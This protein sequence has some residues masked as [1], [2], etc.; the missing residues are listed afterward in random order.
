[1]SLAWLYFLNVI[2]SEI[3]EVKIYYRAFKFVIYGFI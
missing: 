2:E 3:I 1:M